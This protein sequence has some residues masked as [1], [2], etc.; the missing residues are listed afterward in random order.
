MKFRILEISELRFAIIIILLALSFSAVGCNDANN[1]AH[2][3]LARTQPAKPGRQ[4][5]GSII[6]ISTAP[7]GTKTETRTFESGEI[8]RVTRTTQADGSKRAVVEYR[9]GRN[10]ELKDDNDIG[11]LMETSADHIRAA[12]D[13]ALSAT[14]EFGEAVADK[15]KEV[16][17]KAIDKTK[18]GLEKARDAA[19]E[20]AEAAG[21]GIKKAG[22]EIKKAGEKVK[23]KVSQ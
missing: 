23:E 18:E 11:S 6:S 2:S 19:G 21:K 7:D 3:D 13:K 8:A 22:K 12:A 17:G 16:G 15:T 14:K 9:D 10:V 5:D 1:N 4:A 20:A